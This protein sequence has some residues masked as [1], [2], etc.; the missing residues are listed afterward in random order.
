MDEFHLYDD[1]NSSHMLDNT[2]S[3][4]KKVR[5]LG[6]SISNFVDKSYKMKKYTQMNGKSQYE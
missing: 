5:L 4:I 6:I 3:I 2:E 1:E